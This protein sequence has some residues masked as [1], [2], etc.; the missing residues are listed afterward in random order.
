MIENAIEPH[1][2]S[3]RAAVAR[4]AG[5]TAVGNILSRVVGL[6]RTMTV[7]HFFGAG[8]LV[9]AFTVAQQASQWVYDLLVGGN[10]SAA[11]V[12]VL[13]E[14]ADAERRNELWRIASI[15][16]TLA[17][18]VLAA[19]VLIMEAIAPWII[20]LA[21]GGLSAEL[22]R[23]GV[24]L[25]RIITPSLLFLGLAGA[26][27][28]LLYTLK[29]FAFPAFASS[30]FNLGIVITIVVVHRPLNIVS[31]ALGL[32][33]GSVLQLGL[34]LAGLRDVR[35][36]PALS[37]AHPAIRRILRLYLPVIFGV[38]AGIVGGLIDRRLASGVSESAIA[39]MQNATT[40][41]Q[42]ALGLIAAAIAIA[43][44][45]TLSRAASERNEENYQSTLGLGIRMIVTL[46]LPVT[47]LML[48]A[49]RPIVA[50]L[51]QHGAFL[52]SD[53]TMVT[54]ALSLYLIGLPFAAIDQVLIF[55][56]YARKNT[57][58]P[59]MVQFFAIGVY[60]LFALPLVGRWGMSAL[61]IAN[62]AQ[63]A[64]HALAM[65]LLFR[66]RIGWPQGQRIG[67][68]M[69]RAL[70]ATAGL[71]LAAWGA[72][73]LAGQLVDT[74]TLFGRTVVVAAAVTLGAAVYVGLAVLLRLEEVHVVW[75]AVRARLGRP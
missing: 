12:P 10:I 67:A 31:A 47:A 14:Y 71:G 42:T 61:V 55:A 48:A 4:A 62:S 28:G 68:T 23:T 59:N 26:V 74:G 18:L 57:I 35:L 75:Q 46:A 21:G 70:A 66:Q 52:P 54:R 33:L 44:L 38:S 25:L 32:L 40:L 5:I 24:L 43:V 51:F 39:W 34:Q 63:W 73:T 49:G 7:A 58:L 36:R 1:P 17:T 13:S 53:T 65:L 2:T 29:R 72:A 11:L 37:L 64:F 20:I 16:F 56:F 3:D 9:S 19:M 8:G 50:L 27:M 60:L 6:I 15:F 22:Q 69:I 41:I 45:P 30:V